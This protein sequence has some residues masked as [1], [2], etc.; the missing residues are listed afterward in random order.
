MRSS[1]IKEILLKYPVLFSINFAVIMTISHVF[2]LQNKLGITYYF[3]IGILAYLMYY[4]ERSLLSPKIKPKTIEEIIEN[5]WKEN[6][7]ESKLRET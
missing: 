7:K 4:I 6:K 1:K 2:T 3:M 5:A